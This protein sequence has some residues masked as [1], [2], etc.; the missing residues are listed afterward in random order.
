MCKNRHICLTETSAAQVR[1]IERRTYGDR[2]DHR[3]GVILTLLIND[4]DDNSNSNNVGD[5]FGACLL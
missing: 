5:K 3:Q 4:V 2:P 1:G